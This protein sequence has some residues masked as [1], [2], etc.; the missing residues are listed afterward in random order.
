MTK[1]KLWVSDIDVTIMNY[2]GSY[3]SRMAK[4]IEK[5]NAIQNPNNIPSISEKILDFVIL[6]ICSISNFVF[7]FINIPF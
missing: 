7:L 4:L 6:S 2:D 3:T 1:I 5:I